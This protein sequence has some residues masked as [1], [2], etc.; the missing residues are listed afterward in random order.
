[1]EPV[2][3][4]LLRDS[5]TRLV[6]RSLTGDLRS[7]ELLVERYRDVVYRVVA[8]VTGDD[9]ADD[10]TQDV[11]LRAY[12]RLDRFRAEGPFRAWLLQIAHNAALTHAGRRRFGAV[13]LEVL[14]DEPPVEAR[15]T[16]AD[17]VE[18]R[19]RRRRLDT[20][21]KGL[22]PQHRAVLV[23]RDIEGFS[24]EEI[25]QVTEAPVGSVKARLH[26]ARGELIEVLRHNTYDWELPGER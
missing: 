16:P 11:F 3:G 5:D 2:S 12:H 15:G 19:E 4:P 8:R 9:D 7:F 6:E 14:E 21:V 1:V 23:L 20:K 18:S 26:R 25:A 10:V 17:E 22:S 24:Y 13:P